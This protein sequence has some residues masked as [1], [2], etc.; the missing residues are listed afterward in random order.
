[1]QTRRFEWRERESVNVNENENQIENQN[2][3]ESQNENQRIRDRDLDRVWAKKVL[4]ITGIIILFTLSLIL[5][6]DVTPIRYVVMKI[7]QFM[8][9][10]MNF[11]QKVVCDMV[12]FVV[13][14]VFMVMFILLTISIVLLLTI[15][16]LAFIFAF[17]SI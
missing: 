10:Y 6:V 12:S 15:P 16:F 4:L 1:M 9:S 3:I 17:T 7:L 5:Y 2:Q 8:E 14:L 11:S 13:G